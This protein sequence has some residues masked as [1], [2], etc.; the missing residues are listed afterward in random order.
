VAS[1]ECLENI[2]CR[3]CAD[4]CPE[5][6]ISI[7]DLADQPTLLE[8]KCTGCGICVAVCPAGAAAMIRENTADQKVRLFL[9][10]HTKD[11]W[12]P[13]TAVQL[14]N[15]RG[16]SLTLAR[17]V[18]SQAYVNAPHRVLEIEVSNVHLWEGRAFRPMQ[19]QHE[20]DLSAA[21][22][23]PQSLKRSWVTLNGS[24]RLCPTGVPLTVALWQLGQKRFEDAFFC[25]DGSCRMCRVRVDG[26]DRL[27]CQMIVAEGQTIEFNSQ[28]SGESWVCPC[29]RVK[30]EELDLNKS[31]GLP[32]KLTA[33]IT[34]FS[35]GTCKGKW[36]LNECSQF[37]ED[38]KPRPAFQ[39]F[40]SS[41]WRDYWVDDVIEVGEG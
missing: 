29:S 3:A 31:E 30:A 10:D 34:G 1:L 25:E 37:G 26:V 22:A 12:K 33:E 41:P 24:K 35:L 32:Q 40:E 2:P 21:L 9:P 13:Q 27:A 38:Q 19:N 4:A 15:R 11:I 39:G 5:N 8:D 16:D 20:G 28:Y 6:A 23:D 7:L 17:V 14:L 18:A 36:C